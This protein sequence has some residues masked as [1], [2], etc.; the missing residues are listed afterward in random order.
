MNMKYIIEF[1]NG[2]EKNYYIGNESWSNKKSDAKKYDTERGAKMIK[3][4]FCG[5]DFRFNVL[6]I[7]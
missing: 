4:K 2:N 5:K 1:N 7:Y 6:P 3:T